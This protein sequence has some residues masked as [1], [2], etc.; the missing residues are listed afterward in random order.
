MSKQSVKILK[1]GL[2]LVAVVMLLTWLTQP[3]TASNFKF[4]SQQ[5]GSWG[6]SGK[7]MRSENAEVVCY[8]YLNS[9]QYEAA[10]SL[11]CKFK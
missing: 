7:I 9:R 6:Y 11:S 5:V 3:V 2:L 10:A 4:S 1:G 8:Q